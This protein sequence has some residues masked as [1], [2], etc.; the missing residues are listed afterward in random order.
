MGLFTQGAAF[1]KQWGAYAST[2]TKDRKTCEDIRR[3]R[4]AAE[5]PANTEIGLPPSSAI[6]APKLYTI[7]PNGDGAVHTSEFSG[8]MALE[9]VKAWV[10]K[11]AERMMKKLQCSYC[12]QVSHLQ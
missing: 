2:L 9:K 4:T 6:T 1:S 7:S 3:R 5:V 11:E 12:S 10:D 8:S